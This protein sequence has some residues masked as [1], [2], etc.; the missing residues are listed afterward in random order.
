[1]KTIL[2][3]GATSDIAREFSYLV[4]KNYSNLILAGRQKEELERMANDLK[5]RYSIDVHTISFNALDETSCKSL[6]KSAEMIGYDGVLFAHGYLGNQLLAQKD[7]N[8]LN[9]IVII[10]FTSVVWMLEL[11]AS[12]LERKRKGFIASISS[13]AGDRGRQSNYIYGSSKG[14][15]SLYLQGLRNR[16][17]KS[18]VN[19]LTIKPGFVDTKMTMGKI[20][21]SPLVAKPEKVARDILKAINKKKHTLYTLWMW[22]Y[23]MF[24][25]KSIP[26]TIF[27]RM[28]L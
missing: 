22:R 17:F 14:A 2:I 12:Y 27:K 10:N 4:G 26:E 1:M 8:E 11:A 13:V 23:V 25:I 5:V 16:L 24:I 15:L 28:N 7:T 20:K 9:Q 6:M 3:I 18:N 21:D 19:V